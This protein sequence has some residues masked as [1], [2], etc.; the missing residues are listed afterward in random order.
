MYFSVQNAGGPAL[1]SKT[2]AVTTGATRQ[3]IL[4]L[5][6]EPSLRD[7]LG[8]A[9]EALGY[10]SHIAASAAEAEEILSAQP[11]ILATVSDVL[12]LL[13]DGLS[14]ASRLLQGR[15]DQTRRRSGS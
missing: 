11:E 3:R 4:I 7:Q 9:A 8:Q 1:D 6:D 15:P 5:D 10:A 12:M 14:F 2:A 13:E